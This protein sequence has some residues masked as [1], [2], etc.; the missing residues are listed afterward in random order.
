M[1]GLNFQVLDSY[2]PYKKHIP[3]GQVFY[4]NRTYTLY[5]VERPSNFIESIKSA[6]NFFFS[7]QKE[8]KTIKAVFIRPTYSKEAKIAEAEAGNIQGKIADKDVYLAYFKFHSD[9]YPLK[10]ASYQILADKEVMLA[11][12]RQNGMALQ[13]ATYNLQDD[14]D[15]VRAA[16]EQ[17]GMAIRY[18]TYHLQ[19]NFT[20]LLIAVNQNGLALSCPYNFQQMHHKNIVLAAVNQNGLALEFVQLDQIQNK[21]IVLAALKQN[22]AAYKFIDPRLRTD[23]EIILLGLLNEPSR[24]LYL[25]KAS[26]LDPQLVNAV[27]ASLAN[28]LRSLTEDPSQKEALIRFTTFTLERQENYGLHDEHPLMQQVIEA[29]II[30]SSPSNSPKDP[31]QLYARLQKTLKEEPLVEIFAGFRKR[32]NQKEYTYADL[33]KDGPPLEDLFASIETRGVNPVEVAS[34]CNGATL[35]QVKENL[36]G[37]GK[38]IPALLVQKG[39]LQDPISVTHMYLHII[40]KEIAQE[41]DIRVEGRLSNRENRLLKFGSMV[42]ECQTGQA[43]AIEQYYIYCVDKKAL[44]SGQVKIEAIVDGAVQMA[45]KKTLTND[46]LL[47]E[48][49]NQDQVQQ[50]AH[51]TLYLQNRYHKQIGLHHALRFDRNT[52][53]LYDSLIQKDPKEVLKIIRKHLHVQEEVKAHLDRALVTPTISSYMEITK[54]FEKEFGLKD[55]YDHYFELDEGSK[56]IGITLAAVRKILVKLEYVS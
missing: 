53:T 6:V 31:Y 14:K 35:R 22:F 16:V 9:I 52:S 28:K 11:A 36:L 23:K 3:L 49:T 20:T 38:L 32:A 4:L 15:I 17:N 40:L 47:K 10:C 25:S 1:N 48:V 18:A 46:A 24:F 27:Y 51:Q 12:V 44:E 8:P 29:H 33:P 30:T 5:E 54:Y 45:L 13:C 19:H 55:D 37:F 42:K 39:D 50:Q 56:P 41:D 34:L 7:K 21:D 2:F 43:D 26:K